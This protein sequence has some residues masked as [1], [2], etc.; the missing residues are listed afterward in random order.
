M[1]K[2]PNKQFDSIVELIS[3]YSHNNLNEIFDNLDTN[4]GLPYLDALPNP[5]GKAVAQEDYSP[6]VDL[7]KLVNYIKLERNKH[8]FIVRKEPNRLWYVYD[9]EGLLGFANEY[10]LHEIEF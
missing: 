8:Y 6:P 3:Y 10:N 4:L 1:I 2:G 7:K 5:I 9:Q